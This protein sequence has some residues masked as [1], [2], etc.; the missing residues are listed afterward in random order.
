MCAAG[1][2]DWVCEEH[3]K[4]AFEKNFL[5]HLRFSEEI[6][7]REIR[8]FHYLSYFKNNYIFLW[9][10][11]PFKN[12]FGILRTFTHSLCFILLSPSSLFPSR[13]GSWP[14]HVSLVAQ[15]HKHKSASKFT[16]RRCQRAVK[17]MF[18]DRSTLRSY[19]R[20]VGSLF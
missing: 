18:F 11:T 12:E 13:S 14:R 10:W 19:L 7:E 20:Y 2:T 8:K 5:V 15:T 9:R 1:F 6:T 4:D 16:R 17:F 3:F